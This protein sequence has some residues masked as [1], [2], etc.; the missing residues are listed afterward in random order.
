MV[1]FG[2]GATVGSLVAGSLID[3]IGYP[4]F[5]RLLAGVVVVGFA[6]FLVEMRLH[7]SE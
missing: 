2:L 3:A 5:F 4:M 7:H 6:I 1:V